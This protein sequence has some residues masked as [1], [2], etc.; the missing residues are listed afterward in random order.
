MRKILLSVVIATFSVLLIACNDN[1]ADEM[2]NSNEEDGKK[3]KEPISLDWSTGAQGGVWYG[4][5]GGFSTIIKGYNDNIDI[6]ALP[7]G[8]VQNIAM[9]D[10][11]ETELTWNMS[12]FANLGLQGEGPFDEKFDNIR[13]VGNGF[14]DSTFHFVIDANHE[15]EDLEDIFEKGDIKIALT[16]PSQSDDFIFQEIMDH[17]DTSYDEMEENGVSFFQGDYTEQA[18]QF[19]NGNV[20]AIFALS[21]LPGSSITDASIDREL[22]ILE[23]PDDLIEFLEERTFEERIIPADT[24]EQAANGDEDIK[25]VTASNLLLANKDLPDEVVYDML[26]ALN[27]DTDQ[28]E[29]VHAAMEYYDIDKATDNLGDVELHPGAVEF[30]KEEGILE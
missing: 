27:E 16:P 15:Y 9:A 4:A 2:S 12:Y 13:A 11:G 28:L 17:Y 5:G 29:S 23:F 20:D 26:Q 7:G 21:G 14:G 10:N 24:Y 3:Q 25:T 6:K 22:E 18:E 8:T 30:Y 1:S 19:K